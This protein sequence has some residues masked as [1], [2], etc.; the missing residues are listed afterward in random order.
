MEEIK[1]KYKDYTIDSLCC[2]FFS[3]ELEM[4]KDSI[5]RAQ[6]EKEFCLKYQS[7]QHIQNLIRIRQEEEEENKI[8]K[9]K[10]REAENKRFSDLRRERRR[11][12][13][14]KEME[15]RIIKNAN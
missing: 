11:E 12:K 1:I 3:N 14:R 2:L 8:L 15:D 10:E 13:V 4:R 6:F 5:K 9:A 7:N